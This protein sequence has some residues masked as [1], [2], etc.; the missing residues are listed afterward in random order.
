MSIDQHGCCRLAQPGA[1]RRYAAFGLRWRSSLALPFAD[2]SGQPEPADVTVRFG[3]A[4][5]HLPASTG[6]TP[7]CWEASPG[8]ALL[9]V[10]SVA[11]YLVRPQ[12]IVIEPG[13][14]SEDDIVTF[15]VG[16]AATALLQQRG[17]TTAPQCGQRRPAPPGRRGRR[18]APS[19]P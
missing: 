1:H 11:R 9:A 13:D 15:L 10:P 2:A 5:A 12:E 4:P 17:V 6:G 7:H 19:W 16:P 18:P 3:E 8:T 14:G